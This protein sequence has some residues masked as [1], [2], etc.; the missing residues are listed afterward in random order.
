M[1]DYFDQVSLKSYNPA[2]PQITN[3]NMVKAIWWITDG[4][5]DPQGFP[6]KG[7]SYLTL[8]NNGSAPL[9]NL[10]EVR[11]YDTDA[12]ILVMDEGL[13]IK[14]DIGAGGFVS[15][16][17]GELWLGSGRNDQLDPQKIVLT[18]AVISMLNGGG[19]MNAEAIPTYNNWP[20]QENGRIFI[21]QADQHIYK[22]VTGSGWVDKGPASNYS[23]K[24]FDTLYIT[25][26]GP[27]NVPAHLN[28]GTVFAQ[29]LYAR[30]T[31]GALKGAHLSCH[32][33]NDFHLSTYASNST[34]YWKIGLGDGAGG[35]NSNGIYLASE[36]DTINIHHG[37]FRV[38]NEAN[39]YYKIQADDYYDSS[40]QSSATF[41]G[42]L[43]GTAA[44]IRVLGSNPSPAD[45][46][47]WLVS[48]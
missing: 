32:G 3:Y 35:F 39:E 25:K 5:W 14:K 21:F 33:E 41:H 9:L 13:V 43:T 20:N 27:S 7:S 46:E 40:G 28:A 45:G 10:F 44:K 31:E 48:A 18:H 16:N 47:I 12:P 30:G 6:N 29:H 1:T 4:Y 15:S 36:G 24:Y 17:Q 11:D 34:P 42:N 37:N 23:G 26:F 2:P 19:S 38:V 22:Y 8:S